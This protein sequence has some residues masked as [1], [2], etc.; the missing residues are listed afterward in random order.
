[1]TKKSFNSILQI[2][3][4]CSTSFLGLQE[5]EVREKE[6]KIFEESVEQ[7]QKEAQIKGVKTV[8]GSFRVR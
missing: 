1:M 7:A 3:Y 2:L 6:V 8:R 5:L 4:Y